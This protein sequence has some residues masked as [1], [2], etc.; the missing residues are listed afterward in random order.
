MAL[1]AACH[2]DSCPLQASGP[3][4][5]ADDNPVIICVLG[6]FLQMLSGVTV[7]PAWRSSMQYASIKVCPEGS[8]GV[9]GWLSR[10][11]LVPGLC[12]A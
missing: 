6:T 4:D 1:N 9:H 12:W 5:S 8:R 3:V 7:W 10:L 2:K 11:S